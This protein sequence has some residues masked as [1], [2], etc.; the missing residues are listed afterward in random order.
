M[1]THGGC[2]LQVQPRTN[3]HVCHVTVKA[4]NT[5]TTCGFSQKSWVGLSRLLMTC[6]STDQITSD[7]GLWASA[8]L[9]NSTQLS[10]LNPQFGSTQVHLHSIL[11]ATVVGFEKTS[12]TLWN[13]QWQHHA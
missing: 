10:T 2:P 6:T 9:I 1:L 3:M 8:A 5:T 4:Q 7:L 13:Q 11:H 12:D